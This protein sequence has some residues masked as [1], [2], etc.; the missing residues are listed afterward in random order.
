MSLPPWSR[1][2]RALH[3]RPSLSPNQMWRSS[4]ESRPRQEAPP[5]RCQ[6]EARGVYHGSRQLVREQASRTAWIGCLVQSNVSLQETPQACTVYQAS[7]ATASACEKRSQ[8]AR[9]QN[10]RQSVSKQDQR[11]CE[12]LKHR[13]K[14]NQKRTHCTSSPLVS[15]RGWMLV[16]N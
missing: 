11:S 9:R 4:G 15:L 3:P 16:V 6:T 12:Q 10:R 1:K 13:L 5:R 14:N 7:T 8:V 2:L